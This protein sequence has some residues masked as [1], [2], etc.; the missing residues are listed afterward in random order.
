MFVRPA[1]CAYVTPQLCF[2]GRDDPHTHSALLLGGGPLNRLTKNIAYLDRSVVAGTEHS[3]RSSP[4]ERT[5]FVEHR[6]SAVEKEALN[7][8]QRGPVQVLEY[9][10]SKR[11]GDGRL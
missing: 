6:R 4:G 1:P 10:E 5:P 7:H 8:L 3:Q 9:S 11:R 2:F